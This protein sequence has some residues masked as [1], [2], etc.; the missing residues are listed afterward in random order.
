MLLVGGKVV[1]SCFLLLVGIIFVLVVGK[2]DVGLFFLGLEFFLVDVVCL[3][4][5]LYF[6]VII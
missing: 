4:V 3:V 2:G 5:I 1:L 6:D